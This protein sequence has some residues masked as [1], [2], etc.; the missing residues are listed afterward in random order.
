MN[1][2]V[3][4][5]YLAAFIASLSV[6]MAG[7]SYGWINP[8]LVRLLS[9][10]SDL[11]MTPD[12]S[13]W[14]VALIE[15]GDLFSPLPAALLVDAWGRK[16]LLLSTAPMYI[17]SWIL[18]LTTRSVPV[19]YFVRILQGFGMGIVYTVL[20]MYLAEIS[21]PKIRGAIS[22]F[23]EGMWCLGIL[24]EYCLG[25]FLSYQGLSWASL[26]VPVAFLATFLLMP[27]SPYFLV[28]VDRPA[29]A[30][31]SLTWLRG[32]ESTMDEMEEIEVTVKKEMKIE[33]R[34]WKEL[35]ST[36][37]DRRAFLIV[38]VA[39][40]TKFM[41][42]IGAV[43][44]YSSETFSESTR[45]F[46]S[47]DQFTMLMGLLII[48]STLVASFTV[49]HMGRRPLLLISS[50]GCAVFE[51]LAA[52]YY[53]LDGSGVDTSPYSWVAFA[54]VASYC[55]IFSLGVGPLV[56]VLQAELF[57]SNTRGL[58][59]G[60]TTI[61]DTVTSL[62]CMKL[63]EVIASGPGLYIN[64]LIYALFSLAG[65]IVMYLIVPETKGRSF[66]Q[67]QSDLAAT[68][69]ESRD[70]SDKVRSKDSNYTQF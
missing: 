28:M 36:P 57:P 47:P 44:S 59:S 48:V 14:V 41:S 3:F 50:L 11:P 69:N 35:F 4:R 43:L 46:L 52:L 34:S 64:Y 9:P 49:D 22:T 51:M 27:E 31:R 56:P 30:S 68:Y 23:F 58:A 39:T 8:L 7:T 25:P 62:I 2:G 60:I 40:I 10:A 17:I 45:S 15:L 29:E 54:S 1:K 53:Y 42:G 5:Q 65:L 24:L 63:Y 6:L 26:A 66:A 67:I 16:P 37:A 33:T 20:P 12:Q 55:V 32:E 38:Q 18:V 13:S 21:Q 61:T 19:L 70:L